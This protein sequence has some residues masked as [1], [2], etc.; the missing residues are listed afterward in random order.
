MRH[1]V[2]GCSRQDIENLKV[3]QQQLMMSD[4][5][6]RIHIV[7]AVRLFLLKNEENISKFFV[8]FKTE[9]I[10][11]SGTIRTRTLQM[12]IDANDSCR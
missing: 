2:C 12:R 8:S 5:Q 4:R 3:S 1:L 10:E 9:K 11:K 7:P 6:H